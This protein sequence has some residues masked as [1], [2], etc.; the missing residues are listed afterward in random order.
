MINTC[1]REQSAKFY[2]IPKNGNDLMDIFSVIEAYSTDHFLL[3]AL[4]YC[5]VYV[6]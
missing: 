4:T 3:V 6:K 2:I 1:Y 5:S